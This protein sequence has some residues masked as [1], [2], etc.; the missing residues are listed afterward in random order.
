ME[1]NMAEK[2]LILLLKNKIQEETKKN[3]K[4]EETGHE[5]NKQK[6]DTSCENLHRCWSKKI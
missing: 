2:T 4:S 1:K 5:K 6:Q 3:S